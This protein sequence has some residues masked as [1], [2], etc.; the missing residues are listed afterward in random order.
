VAGTEDWTTVLQELNRDHP[1]SPEAMRRSYA[2]W[3]ERARRFLLER[4]LVTLPEGEECLVEPSPPFQ[5]PV[6]AVASYA[7]PPA[8][9]P[10]RRG[11]FFVPFRPTA[12][13]P[14]RSSSGFR[15]TATQASPR[16]RSTR[17]TRGITGTSS[18]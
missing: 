4:G 8:F 6:L 11:H 12:P 2:D 1:E 5:R 3:T 18:R 14:R 9:S 7:S 10:S 16:P 15:T 17:R 13:P